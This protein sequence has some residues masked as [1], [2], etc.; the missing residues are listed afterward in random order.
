VPGIKGDDAILRKKV[1]ANIVASRSRGGMRA[2]PQ[3]GSTRKV[4][5]ISDVA[6][7]R[8]K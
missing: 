2:T 1:L 7:V 5:K 3:S 6:Q 4:K 8:A